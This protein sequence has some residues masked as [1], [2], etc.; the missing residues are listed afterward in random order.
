MMESARRISAASGGEDSP[1]WRKASWRSAFDTLSRAGRRIMSY[2]YAAPL[3]R[4]GTPPGEAGRQAR[5]GAGSRQ[6]LAAEP[7]SPPSRTAAAAAAHGP[8][9]GPAPTQVPGPSG[10]ERQVEKATALVHDLNN[11]LSVVQVNLQLLDRE[12]ADEGQRALVKE[13]QDATGLCDELIQ[14]LCAEPSGQVVRWLPLDINRE[15][16]R[17][18]NL[19]RKCVGPEIEVE[20]D[21][22]ENLGT[23][24]A[25][26]TLFRNAVL[27]LVAN[28]RDS[29]A[30]G[31]R[32][33]IATSNVE[34]DA[35]AASSHIDA[36][37]GAYVMLSLRDTGTGIAPETLRRVFDPYF[38][39][40]TAG[41]S[42][43]VGLTLVREFCQRFE[44]FVRVDSEVGRGTIVSVYLPRQDT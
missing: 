36:K 42:M 33:V 9:L 26:P 5:E 4:S 8:S 44:G 14:G 41:R 24:G 16:F 32:L 43:G 11:L 40:K 23:I 6:I 7:N 39:T 2:R 25:D 35:S 18:D 31:G 28:A 3:W 21:L 20:Q 22:A 15:L 1:G 34:I 19:I 37:P 38:T 27:N 10:P 30:S 17:I 12:L 13:A 29:M